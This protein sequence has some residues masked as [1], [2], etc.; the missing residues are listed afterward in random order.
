MQKDSDKRWSEAYEMRV[1]AARILD[2]NYTFEEAFH[3][4]RRFW[5]RLPGCGK[6]TTAEIMGVIAKEAER[7]HQAN[8]EA[9]RAA[10][11]DAETLRLR[12]ELNSLNETIEQLTLRRNAIALALGDAKGF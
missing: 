3:K 9:V 5:M 11:I 8:L 1:S 2:G 12:A 6:V 7:R 4:P 10:S